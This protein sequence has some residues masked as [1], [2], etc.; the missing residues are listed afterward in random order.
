MESDDTIS[1][2]MYD[3]GATMIYDDR[4]DLGYFSYKNR[5]NHKYNG[6]Y[7]PDHAS[8]FHHWQ[9]GLIMMLGAQFLQL[10][11]LANEAREVAEEF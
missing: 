9:I 2:I 6:K 4:A 7:S 11:Q 10:N 1:K 8:P 3:I 5:R